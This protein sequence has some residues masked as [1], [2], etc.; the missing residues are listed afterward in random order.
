MISTAP[1]P[2][3][4]WPSCRRRSTSP[5]LSRPS[6]RSRQGAIKGGATVEAETGEA[7]AMKSASSTRARASPARRQRGR[8]QPVLQR[9]LPSKSRPST[10]RLSCLY[11]SPS[12][13]PLQSA[14]GTGR[15]HGA[16][17]RQG[18]LRRFDKKLHRA[19]Q[20]RRRGTSACAR[21][22][23][24]VRSEPPRGSASRSSRSRRRRY[25]SAK[26]PS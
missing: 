24:I 23:A 11:S 17:A 5:M 6:T 25:S 18:V 14:A 1:R 26:C 22:P 13:S 4:T 10:Y 20:G 9:P 15:G 21:A 19:A 2:Q 7:L 8:T 12:F 16:G 3:P